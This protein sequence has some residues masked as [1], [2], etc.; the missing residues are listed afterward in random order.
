MRIL[1]LALLLSGCSRY[2]SNTESVRDNYKDT[3]WEYLGYY[4]MCHSYVDTINDF[5]INIYTDESGQLVEKIE[6]IFPASSGYGFYSY[7][8]W[9][10]GCNCKFH[11][12]YAECRDKKI[13]YIFVLEGD[14]IITTVT[15]K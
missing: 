8:K 5:D 14:F 12:G 4:D 11:E 3:G 7:L 13:K 1:I 15:R 6:Y 9:E 10:Q 2:I